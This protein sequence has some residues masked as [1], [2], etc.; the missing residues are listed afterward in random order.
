MKDKKLNIINIAALYVGTIMGAGFASGREGWQFFGVFGLKGYGGIVLTGLL[1]MALGMMAAYI[2]RSLDT[3][4][5]GRIIVF[6]DNPKLI[7]AAGYFIAAILYTV[8]ISMSAAGG[9]FLSQQFGIHRSV[10]GA[11][12]TVM[13]IFTVLGNFER[14]SKVFRSVIPILFAIDIYLC[15]R[16][17]FSDISQSGAQDG[18]PVSSMA[19][20]W[21]LSAIL[22]VSYNILGMIPI[23]A[24]G[25]RKAKSAKTAVCGAGLGG[26]LLAFLTVMLLTALRKDMAFT[27]SMDLPMLA[28]SARLSKAANI[29]FGIVL[30]MAVYSAA[31]STYYGFSTK[32][33]ESPKKKYILIIAAFI[34]FACGLT[35]FK[36]IVAYMYPIEGYI[37]MFVIISITIHFIKVYRQNRKEKLDAGRRE[38]Q[39]SGRFSED[40]RLS[41]NAGIAGAAEN[42]ISGVPKDTGDIYR[43][44]PGSSRFDY[45]ENIVRVT[46]GKG[47]EALLIFGPEKTALYDCGMAYCH[48]GLIS[49]IETALSKRGRNRLDYVLISHTHY[50]HIGALPYIL[51]RWEDVTVCGAEKAARVFER[52]GAKKTMKRL[53]CAARDQFSDSKEDVAVEPLRVDRTVKENDRIDLGCGTCIFV[54]E[55][56]GHTD[57]SL[58]YVL[59]P[60]S[61]MFTSES[62]GV[63]R[64]P[65]CMH[66]AILKSYQDTMEAAQKCRAYGAK[67]I[68]SPHYGILPQDFNSRYFDMYIEAAEN[69][70]DF[71]L[72]KADEGLSRD[73][74]LEKFEEEYW[75]E[76]RATSQPKAAFLENSRYVIKH[77]LE[78]FKNV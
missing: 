54:L 35:G 34:G 48:E 67:R 13:V 28:Y 26:L 39:T 7:H 23:M 11:V 55:T 25:A 2:A 38:K 37:G 3:E 66:T 72:Q 62:T 58:T 77:I 71:I 53:G 27:Q 45:P 74:I 64:N 47:G 40:K 31:T 73:Q 69:E 21:L 59:E 76:E 46:A 30:F 68:V 78:V 5:L 50:D 4:D 1:F 14:I 43:D 61:V 36:T 6:S 75:S 56:K 60:D 22:F 52:D 20:N 42:C 19:P 9:S 16:V 70:R 41:E 17:I 44:F 29:A 24:S 57:C 18:F 63:F 10:G 51:K 8:I 33:K 12:I 49:N 15:I 32:L 65:S